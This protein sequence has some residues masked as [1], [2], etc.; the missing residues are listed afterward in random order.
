MEWICKEYGKAD[1]LY[2]QALED[3]APKAHELKIKVHCVGLNFPDLLV[4]QGKDQ[5]RPVLPFSPCG[6]MSGEVVAM[7][8]EVAGF[9]IGDRVFAGGM[10]WG[11]SKSEVCVAQQNVYKVPGGMPMREAA[12]LPC[13]FGTA[14]HCLKDRA[15][16][17]AGET[18]AILGAAGGVGAAT[19]QVAKM[20]GAKVIACAST[21]QKRD[22]CLQNGADIVLDYTNCDLKQELKRL[23]DGKGVDVI[24]DPVGSQYSEPALRAI[25]YDG[26]YMVLGFTAGQIARIPLN[27]PLL[28]NCQ[29]IGVFW[30][31]FGRKFP[32]KNRRNIQQILDWYE[33]GNI[34]IHVDAAFEFS[35][36]PQAFAALEARIIKGKIILEV[37]KGSN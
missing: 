14:I 10:V 5:Y 25:A 11:C 37:R 18:V 15:Q 31:T 21:Q 32:A 22:F 24:C 7:G 9:N 4:I 8:E 17:K 20:M 28:K 3:V 16:L 34:K 30:S 6:E 23:T 27:L 33:E 13:V 12:V 26:R 1:S 36:L 19:I 35:D 29:I 2:Y